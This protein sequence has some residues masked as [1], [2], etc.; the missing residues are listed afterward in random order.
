MTCNSDNV[1]YTNT[2]AH[3]PVAYELHLDALLVLILRIYTQTH[4][5][6]KGCTHRVGTMGQGDVSAVIIVCYMLIVCTDRDQ[7]A[8][9]LW[10]LSRL[11]TQFK[12][13]QRPDF[14]I[15]SQGVNWR[16]DLV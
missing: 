11:L 13:L 14:T 6:T 8:L 5:R 15:L 3:V 10:C 9:T 16:K 2:Q 1:G 4:T 12:C 7:C